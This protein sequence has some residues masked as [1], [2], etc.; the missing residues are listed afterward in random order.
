M[1]LGRWLKGIK[2]YENRYIPIATFLLGLVGYS[3]MPMPVQAAGFFAPAIPSVGVFLGALGQT[4]M[5][6]GVHSTAKNTVIPAL[7]STLGW[8]LG[9]FLKIEK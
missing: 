1:L 6:T 7:K 5:V 9:R 4:L 2:E 3:V 8:L